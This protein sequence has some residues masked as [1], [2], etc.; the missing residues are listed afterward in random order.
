MEALSTWKGLSTSRF[1]VGRSDPCAQEPLLSVSVNLPRGGLDPQRERRVC[2]SL[3]LQSAARL[4]GL[5][6]GERAAGLSTPHMPGHHLFLV[7][8]AW[9]SLCH[10]IPVAQEECTP[11][12]CACWGGEWHA[13]LGVGK[14]GDAGFYPFFRF[15]PS[16]LSPLALHVAGPFEDSAI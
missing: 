7:E 9:S 5:Y 3:C 6:K 1:T 8:H 10:L 15:Q 2:L 12:P 14:E 4:P 13:P 16:L 11:A